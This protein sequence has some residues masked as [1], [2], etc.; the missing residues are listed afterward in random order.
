MLN[1][2]RFAAEAPDISQA[3]TRMLKKNEVAFLATVSATERP[4]IHPFVPKIVEGRLVAFIMDSS[5]KIRD[6]QVRRQYSLHAMPGDKDE[7]F[8]VSGEANCCNGEIEFR[9]AAAR[10]MGFATGVDEFHILYQFMIDKALWT[11]WLDFG[12]T[13]HRPEYVRWTL[14]LKTAG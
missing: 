11:T 3:G 10:A 4:R 7:E 8:F 5:P 12:T 14:K 1:W 6:L 9:Q 13:N 2:D